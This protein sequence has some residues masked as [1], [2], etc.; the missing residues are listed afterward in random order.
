MSS[1]P[2]IELYEKYGNGYL[3]GKFR[4]A[5]TKMVYDFKVYYSE[6]EKLTFNNGLAEAMKNNDW[7]ENK[8]TEYLN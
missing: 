4:Y 3:F 5:F 8:I 1:C 2:E 6:A 7:W